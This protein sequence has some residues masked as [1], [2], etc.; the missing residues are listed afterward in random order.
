VLVRHLVGV[1][2]QILSAAGLALRARTEGLTAARVDRARLADRSIVLA[3]AMRGTLHLVAAEDHG[4]LTDL[5]FSSPGSS[6][7]RLREMGVGSQQTTR[8]V[9][10]IERMLDRDGPLTRKEI[11]E[12]LRR[13]DLPTRG[14][15]LPH[16]LW[17]AASRA[18]ICC[19]PD[20]DGERTYILARDWLGAPPPIDRDAA[21]AEL[22]V[23]YLRAHGPANP[24]DLSYWAGISLTD[25][26]RGWRAIERR[27]VEVPT[28]RRPLWRLRTAEPEAP[29]AVVR[30]LPSFDEYILGWKDR[31]FVAGPE[32][33]RR[34][35]PGAGW[36]HPAVVA[37]GRG[38]GTW[39][40]DRGP[41][42]TR[43]EVRPFTRLSP[44]D[45]RSLLAEAE[46][47]GAY[48]R[49]PADLT[50]STSR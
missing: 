20:R 45:R 40:A 43:I 21:V 26:R 18:S 10:A 39:K 2:A 4:W 31:S 24:V 34:I 12:R 22:A 49:R 6:P 47:L 13:R 48:L 23:R 42:V 36:F 5:T 19:G 9:R 25:A 11:G 32:H 33:L 28:A 7:R 30:L 3:W 16:L 35:H 15:I 8:A 44:A 14:Q 38:V 46:A 50:V 41:E 29:P 17:L 37:D 27:L 1:Q